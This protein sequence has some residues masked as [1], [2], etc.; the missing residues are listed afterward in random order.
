MKNLII[1]LTAV[2]MSMHVF[3]INNEPEP[4]TTELLRSKK[5]EIFN[6][7]E[8]A[9]IYLKES[10]F[11]EI[12]SVVQHKQVHHRIKIY[13]K[14]GLKYG[15]YAISCRGYLVRNIKATTYNLVDGIITTNKLDSKLIYEEKYKHAVHRVT[16]AMP[17]VKEGSVIDIQYEMIGM[18]P[19]GMTIY[20]Q[21]EIP[22]DD[23]V[24]ELES[25]EDA[26]V[27]KNMY[28][29]PITL[30]HEQSMKN[31]GT[32]IYRVDKYRA[33]NIPAI[34]TEP[35]VISMNNYRSRLEFDIQSFN[36]FKRYHIDI[37]SDWGALAKLLNKH[38]LFGDQ[39][40]ANPRP[41]ADFIDSVVDENEES[42]IIKS[43]AFVRDCFEWNGQYGLFAENGT[44]KLMKE[45]SG[46]VADINLL[47]INLLKK[48]K[49]RAF[50]VLLN[51]A[52]IGFVHADHPS[53]GQ[54]NYVIAA[55]E[56]GDSN[57][58]LL[59]ATEKK[60]EAG[61]LPVRA[62]NVLG[63]ILKGHSIAEI[64]EI[65][66]PNSGHQTHTVVCEIDSTMNLSGQ[67]RIIHS[68]YNASAFRIMY[69]SLQSI[70]KAEEYFE[71]Q[72]PHMQLTEIKFNGL[73]EKDPR[74][75]IDCLFKLQSEG[76][77]NE[78]ICVLNPFLGIIKP[79]NNFKTET[80]NFPV[81]YPNTGSVKFII[82][83]KKPDNLI[84]KSVP[85]SV[86]YVNQHTGSFT[87]TSYSNGNTITIQS[88]CSRPYWIVDP[89]NYQAL[90][91]FTILANEKQEESIIFS[92]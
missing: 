57:F 28:G 47:L 43:Y 52:D 35:Y 82:T 1:V 24:I 5:H 38:D 60:L 69:D 23:I 67:Y 54:L 49:I 6:E 88:M 86:K 56:T 13:K 80:R 22:I 42:K 3:S 20:F 34:E 15:N 90:R 91:Q 25:P 33:K 7:A 70:G 29:T 75:V 37:A 92:K 17:E 55:V 68:G 30:E 50:P 66:N 53:L 36:I 8:A 16:F 71:N 32:Q 44:T 10:Y 11:Y 41:I 45:K 21:H 61:Y 74:V 81:F 46:N 9:T 14:Q 87:Y 40:L 31:H 62:N 12:G 76:F 79:E 64:F 85:E 65:S 72:F 78:E 18:T 77:V 26:T 39:L 4:V 27:S 48:Q 19:I 2:L 59:D 89:S 83:I 51:T 58:I 63:V 84:V 73:S